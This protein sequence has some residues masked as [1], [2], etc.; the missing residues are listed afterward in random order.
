MKLDSL[1]ARC[2]PR[3]TSVPLLDLLGNIFIR[4][5][6]WRARFLGLGQGHSYCDTHL[7]LKPG[8]FSSFRALCRFCL[9][10]LMPE[11]QSDTWPG[12]LCRLLATCFFV[13]SWSIKNSSR[14]CVSLSHIPLCW[15]DIKY[16][17]VWEVSVLLL[18]NFYLLCVPF[19]DSSPGP[20]FITA[21]R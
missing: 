15:K 12:Q 17:T 20:H 1:S 7:C 6:T 21:L 4:N 10:T 11:P 9:S 5:S 19:L 8:S 3:H 2:R 14:D 13:L 18:P 16:T